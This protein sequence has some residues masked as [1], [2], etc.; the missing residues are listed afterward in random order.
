M[1]FWSWLFGSKEARAEK[2]AEKELHRLQYERRMT[3]YHNAM[4]YEA[5]MDLST[6]MGFSL[7][8][9]DQYESVVLEALTRFSKVPYAVYK[10]ADED[11]VFCG[12][13]QIHVA[14]IQF[15]VGSVASVAAQQQQVSKLSD[16]F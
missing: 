6:P 8:I 7:T 3:D 4:V 15:P 12:N 9:S 10:T 1:G 5:L 2:A 16:A 11:M 14:Y 13:C